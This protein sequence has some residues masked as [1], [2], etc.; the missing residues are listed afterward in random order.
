LP[1][2]VRAQDHFQPR[3]YDGARVG[4]GPGFVIRA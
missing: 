2:T 1:W 3:N 4:N